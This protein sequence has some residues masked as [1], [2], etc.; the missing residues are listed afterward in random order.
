[1]AHPYFC[2]RTINLI[3]I[4][5]FSPNFAC[6]L[7]LWRVVL[8]LVMGKFHHFWQSYLPMTWQWQGIIVSLFFF[9][10]QELKYELEKKIDI[11]QASIKEA[12]DSVENNKADKKDEGAQQ[13][14]KL[15]SSTTDL[16][17]RF[18]TVSQCVKLCKFSHGGRPA[19]FHHNYPKYVDSIT[20]YFT[21]QGP[22]VRS[23]VSLKS[24]LVVKM[25]TVLVSTISDSQLF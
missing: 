18:D 13:L 5:E 24:L 6:A 16:K 11:V 21:I 10:L 15:K 12:L 8:R 23:I 25:L 1:M 17:V 14:Q 4:S 9:H 20:F 2:Y 19:I 7:I 22:V 3:N